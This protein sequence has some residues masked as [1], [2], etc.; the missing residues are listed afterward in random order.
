MKHTAPL[1]K[2]PPALQDL[3][4]CMNAS[5][6]GTLLLISGA[7]VFDP[8]PRGRMDI[9]VGGG[10]VLR[11][12]EGG[13]F[14]PAELERKGLL[15]VVDASGLIA[16]PGLVDMHV[17]LTGGGG[18]AGPASRV[19]QPR[20]SEFIQGGLTTVVG[21]LGTDSI[22][23]SLESLSMTVAGLNL[24]PIS[25]FMYT[26]AY[27]TLPESPNLLGSVMKDIALLETVVGVKVSALPSQPG[28]ASDRSVEVAISDFR[29]SQPTL[30]HMVNLAADAKVGGMLG[31]KSGIVYL[32]IGSNVEKLDMLWDIV[33]ITGLP[34]TQV[35]PTHVGRTP[36]LAR[37]SA[38]WLRDGGIVD[39]TANSKA[40][41]VVEAYINAGLPLERVCAFGSLPKFDSNKQL[42]GY[43]YAKPTR[44]VN[45]LREMLARG[46]NLAEIL[47]LVTYNPSAT[48]KLPRG[49][50]RIVE[51]GDADIALWKLNDKATEAKENLVLK[52]LFSKGMTALSSTC[53]ATDMF[54]RIRS[55]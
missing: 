25:A 22:S 28:I 6:I 46:H 11:M 38:M 37:A 19:P 13:G 50:G 52:G 9:L 44:L 32:H 24:L 27:K 41:D 26:G 35:V 47:P 36:E 34:K 23:R 7:N 10:K 17:H 49:K 43:S 1:L 15:R 21:L 45:F 2:S 8:T 40:A 12:F 42:I 54:G 33:N 14:D 31:G 18:E 16:T 3:P 39:V 51:G 20:L 48:L 29:G 5:D 55:T 4:P 30:S 53:V